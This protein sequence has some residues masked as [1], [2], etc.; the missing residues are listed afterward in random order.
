MLLLKCLYMKHMTLT[1]DEKLV[2][3]FVVL[4][5]VTATGCWRIFK[6]AIKYIHYSI[7]AIALNWQNTTEDKSLNRNLW[8]SWC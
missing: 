5:T 8:N 7:C 4:L 1:V 2:F 6:S 3:I